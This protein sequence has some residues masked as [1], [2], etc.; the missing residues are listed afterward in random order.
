MSTNDITPSQDFEKLLSEI[1][2]DPEGFSSF[3]IE[4]EPDFLANPDRLTLFTKFG[5]EGGARM[6]GLDLTS[7]NTIFEKPEILG[8]PAGG[9]ASLKGGCPFA[10][11]GHAA[12]GCGI[13]LRCDGLW[14]NFICHDASHGHPDSRKKTDKNSKVFWSWSFKNPDSLAGERLFPAFERGDHVELAQAVVS[15]L[16]DAAWDSGDRVRIFDAGFAHKRKGRSPNAGLWEIV[17]TDA[18]MRAIRG[19]AGEWVREGTGAKAK[20]RRI[21]LTSSAI[22]GIYCQVLSI[23][24]Q[25]LPVNG[26]GPISK[27]ERLAPRVVFKGCIFSIE[28]M[29]V[30]GEAQ[31][32]EQ[33]AALEE[34]LDVPYEQGVAA[35][36]KFLK[37]L[38]DVWQ[39][40]ADLEARISFVQ[41]WIG[42]MLA[43][44]VVETEN[45]LLLQGTPKGRNGK[46]RFIKILEGLV[47]KQLKTGLS[48]KDLENSFTLSCLQ[49]SR[50]NTLGDAAATLVN[51]SLLKQVLSGDTIQADR[52]HKDSISITPKAAWVISIND[53]FTPS[54]RDQAIY[55][56]FTVLTFPRTFNS[57]ENHHD[58]SDEILEEEKAA[59]IMW[60]I[61]GL[62]RR[63][64][65]RGWTPVPSAA[66][67]LASWQESV[68]PVVYWLKNKVETTDGK[69][70]MS[71]EEH[72]AAYAE[73]AKKAGHRAVASQKFFKEPGIAALSTRVTIGGVRGRAHAVRIIPDLDLAALRRDSL[74]EE[75]L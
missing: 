8:V 22:E 55:R 47:P 23:L 45:H 17:P 32:R 25:S 16:G 50:L 9:W 36:Q 2:L 53:S 20:Y 1:S 61:E 43:G 7:V 26:L 12:K 30:I 52:K 18:V 39:G 67:A 5:R 19:L 60:A 46:S 10:P 28:R 33:Y 65:S 42:M 21:S 34:A 68:D 24:R 72:Y 35:P 49:F 38:A 54:E 3:S 41:E 74:L 44:K 58:V 57:S 59:I 13:N 11:Y 27:F 15:R 29:A 75:I 64:A 71:A 63:I 62:K 4:E 69:Y 51:S 48:F 14:L 37:F 70:C 73:W 40:E 56:R 31:M 6:G 66:E